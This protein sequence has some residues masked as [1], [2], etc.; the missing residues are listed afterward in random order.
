MASQPNGGAV[1]AQATDF[2]ME[3]ARRA[4]EFYQYFQP[5]DLVQP[6]LRRRPSIL[7]ISSDE[8]P[9]LSRALSP[10]CQ[11][12]ALRMKVR[13]AMINVMDREVMYFLS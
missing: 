7:D 9:D 10:L 4:R 12:A 8:V 11:L 3:N 13:K 6:H 5:D 2:P 1:S